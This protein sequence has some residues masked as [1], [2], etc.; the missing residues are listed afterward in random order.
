MRILFSLMAVLYLASCQKAGLPVVGVIPKGASHQFW[1][2]VHAGAVQAGREY[3]L[4][5]EWNAP[6]LEIDAPRQID[7][8]QSMVTRKLAGIAIAP[9][10]R[11]ALVSV[12]ERASAQGVPVAVYDS[13]VDTNQRITYVAT[14]NREGGRM[15]AR[16]L[17]LVLLAA[18]PEPGRS[19]RRQNL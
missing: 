16:R 17:G 12:I 8:A 9:V 19:R 13:D 11:K 5:I 4:E 3:G 15:A 14:D 6:A 1:Q 2:T 10:D 7:I 18:R